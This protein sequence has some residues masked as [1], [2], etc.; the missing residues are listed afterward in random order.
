MPETTRILW[1]GLVRIARRV[2]AF[3]LTTFNPRY[4]SPSD[5]R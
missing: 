1:S 2:D 3:T 4:P 5:R